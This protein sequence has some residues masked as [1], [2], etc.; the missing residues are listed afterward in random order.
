MNEDL[1]LKNNLNEKIRQIEEEKIIFSTEIDC[2]KRE[3]NEKSNELNNERNKFDG[4]IRSEQSLKLKYESLL[5]SLDKL[6]L[7][8]D[9]FKSENFKTNEEKNKL[10]DEIRLKNVNIKLFLIYHFFFIL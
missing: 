9:Q 3:L 10:M 7:E 6:S 4:L 5:N 8:N 1:K 2:L